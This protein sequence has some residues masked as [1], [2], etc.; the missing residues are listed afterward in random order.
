MESL[1]ASLVRT[2]IIAAVL[3][4]VAC[5]LVITM[6]SQWRLGGKPAL[7][8]RAERPSVPHLGSI[9]LAFACLVALVW[10]AVGLG[11]WHQAGWRG[12]GFGSGWILVLGLIDDLWWELPPWLKGAGQ[13]L[14][15]VVLVRGGIVMHVVSLPPWLN[16]LLTVVWIVGIT[17]A[18]NLLDI[19]DGLAAAI[20]QA[21]AVAFVI[22]A[23]WAGQG[24]LAL[25]GVAIVGSLAGFLVFNWPPAQLYMGDAGSQ[26][27][28]FTL[29][30][31]SLAI[32]Y[33]PL[34]REIALLTPVVV[35]GL[36]IYDL[37]FVSW[38]R[39]R[40][41]RSP[42]QKSRDHAALRLAQQSASTRAAVVRMASVAVGFAGVGLFVARAHNLAGGLVVIMVLVAVLWWGRS[43]GLVEIDTDA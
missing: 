35:L 13:L 17:N 24:T 28:G 10:S 14:A 42:F 39:L 29:A 11:L 25:L 3:S 1:A 22:L 26:W 6:A 8:R 12:W 5:R 33:A 27:L 40:R 15:A 43:L 7:R 16:Q 31:L 23:V 41:G 9:A 21:A 2:G 4:F 20:A 34:G 19:L 18:M 37:I 30:T 38:M 36:P 32:S